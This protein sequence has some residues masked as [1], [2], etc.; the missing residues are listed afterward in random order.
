MLNL[1]VSFLL[2]YGIKTN[3]V[4]NSG[5]GSLLFQKEKQYAKFRILDTLFVAMGTILCLMI[6]YILY[7]YIYKTYNMLY[8]S[9]IISVLVV[10]IWNLIVSKIF[11]K[12]SHFVHY[13][14]EKSN[15]F[16]FDSVFILSVIFSID[17]A[18]YA[19]LDF[20]ILAATLAIVIFVTNLIFGFFIEDANKTNVDK[21]YL[22]VPSRLFMLAIFSIILYY[23]SQLIK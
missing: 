2:L 11:G 19:M 10:G 6:S 1:F 23:A 4:L 7:S 20:V 15:S 13:L 9:V 3:V 18:A 22:N 16:V 5:A 21:H 14:Y 17:M 12:M 8:L